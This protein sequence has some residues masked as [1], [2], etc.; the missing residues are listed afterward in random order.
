MATTNLQDNLNWLLI[1]AS[2]TV[3][4]R[5][6]KLSEEYDLT[7]M[8]ALTLCLLEPG[9]TVPM[10]TISDL[11]ACDPSNVTGIV[12]R[13]SVG[14]YIERRESHIDRRVKTVKLTEAGVALRNKLLP[15]ITENDASN[16]VN[17]SQDEIAI[18][19][20]LLQKTLPVS[21]TLKHNVP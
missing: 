3:K 18:L 5:L 2:M 6:M 15:R 4:Q 10:S 16:L 12:E 7:L 19:K 11:L 17:L 14:S 21:A 9:D 8:Q 20:K 1:R 13:L